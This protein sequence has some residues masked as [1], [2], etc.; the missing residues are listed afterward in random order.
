MV[1]VR[2]V[3]AET[4]PRE[5]VTVEWVADLLDVN[6]KTVRRWCDEGKLSYV[7]PGRVMRIKR[8][9]LDALLNGA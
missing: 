9:S 3:K 8:S 1:E 4:P 7:R 6:V 2:A 5:Y